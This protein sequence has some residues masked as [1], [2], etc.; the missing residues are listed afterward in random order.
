MEPVEKNLNLI[1]DPWILVRKADESV[2]MVSIENVLLKAQDYLELA[3]ETPTQDVAV[4]RMLEAIL[5]RIFF[6]WNEEGEE[7]PLEDEK[8]ALERWSSLWEEERFPEKPVKDYLDSVR[9]QFWLRDEN[10]PAFQSPNAV[11]GTTYKTSK[12]IGSLSESAN[13]VRLFQQRAYADKQSIGMEEAARWLLNLNGFDD[14]SSKPSVKGLPSVGAGWLGKIGLIYAKGENLFQT[15]MLNLIFLK[16]GKELWDSCGPYWETWKK[17]DPERA[18]RI[19]VPV[20]NDLAALYTFPSRRILLHFNDQDKVDGFSLL[21]G[22]VFERANASVE[23][24]TIWRKE[25]KKGE[26][27]FFPRRHNPS[28]HLWRDFPILLD[29]TNGDN[30][31][32]P[33]IVRWIERLREEEM[34]PEDMTIEFEAPY[35]Q[36]GDKDFFVTDIS[37]QSMT[38]YPSLVTEAGKRWRSVIEVEIEKIDKIATYFGFFCKTIALAGGKSGDSVKNEFDKGIRSVYRSIDSAFSLWITSLNPKGGEDRSERQQEWEN[39][40]RSIFLRLMNELASHVT[41][42][43]LIGRSLSVKGKEQKDLYSAAKAEMLLKKEIYSIYP[44]QAEQN[45]VQ[46]G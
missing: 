42:D 45:E 37:K 26:T 23:Q 7:A 35:V 27:N 2:E 16:N 11:R 46:N 32:V 36:Y 34:I 31:P 19:E 29:P 3:G 10:E 5:Q 13:K 20:P 9:D 15:L 41:A 12:L 30:V 1:S 4:I 39:E 24:N 28:R 6:T 25:E 14:T 21:G 17:T 43:A 40:A 44:A 33:G 38:I 18:E 8:E 22:Q